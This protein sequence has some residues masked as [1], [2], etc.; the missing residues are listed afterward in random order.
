MDISLVLRVISFGITLLWG[1]VYDVLCSRCGSHLISSHHRLACI[2][3]QDWSNVIPDLCFAT[4]GI[5]F[6]FTFASQKDIIEL[7][8]C[9]SAPCIRFMF[10][11]ETDVNFRA[12]ALINSDPSKSEQSLDRFVLTPVKPS[13]T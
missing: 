1:L 10:E 5:L 6:F 12:L 7:W 11:V 2:T 3:I 9:W 13:L 4:F 8:R